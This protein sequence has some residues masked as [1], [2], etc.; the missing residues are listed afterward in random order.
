MVKQAPAKRTQ[1]LER[2][3]PQKKESGASILSS[4]IVIRAA[5]KELEDE[6]II[7]RSIEYMFDS[8]NQNSAIYCS[9]IQL[10]NERFFDLLQPQSLN[11][12]IELREDKNTG[13]F[14]EGVTEYVVSNKTDCLSLLLR[15]EKNRLI[16]TTS[17]N[18]FSSRSH[19]IFKLQIESTKPDSNGFLF[20]SKLN[21]CDLAGSEKIPTDMKVEGQHFLELKNI[22]LSL[23]TL[24]RVIYALAC[25]AKHIPY[26]DSKITNFLND[27]IGGK[28]KTVIFANVSP[29]EEN[30]E[31]TI[32]T[33]MFAERAKKIST[34]PK[35]NK[36]NASDDEVVRKLQHELQYYKKILNIK[37]KGSL[38]SELIV[39]RRENEKLKSL[40]FN[41]DIVEKLKKEN[42]N[43]RK[44]L[45]ALHIENKMLVQRQG[46]YSDQLESD[47][48]Q[49]SDQKTTE[50][51]DDNK[52]EPSEQIILS[53]IEEAT[54]FDRLNQIKLG[55]IEIT[56][57]SIEKNR[58]PICTLKF[59]CKHYINADQIPIN[60]HAFKQHNARSFKVY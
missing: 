1:C 58:C 2:I 37:A 27:S 32:N 26:R 17:Y 20:T 59:P 52:A 9:F 6:G 44:Q 36:V 12:P 8:I 25:S 51:F 13:F 46:T 41:I 22:N 33:L 10:Y 40:Q 5:A 49:S 7:P 4:N 21:L 48:V 16:R 53:N 14:L 18:E 35:E 38:E 39:L 24:G 31:D 50:D 11:K 30:T 23:T 47:A 60:K 15:G 54:E 19:T 45:Q 29:L 57:Q 55:A 56:K 43:M 34:N 28:T 3:G 42:L